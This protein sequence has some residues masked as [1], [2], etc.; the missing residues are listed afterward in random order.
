M[1]NGT[2][3]GH[4]ALERE[5]A[6]FYGCRSAIVFS[7]GYVANLGMLSALTGPGDVILI[8]SDCHASI[9]DG[10]RLSGA[11][12]IRFR[13]S[14]PSDLNKR[15]HRLGE[16]ATNALIVVEGIYS[17]LGDRAPLA[18]LAAVKDDYGAYLFVDEA[19]SL[20]VIGDH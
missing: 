6:D 4:V 5:L 10:C 19:H 13:H 1:A 17:M 15:L 2:F 8:D 16:R 20:G 9:Y 14:D 11:E 18:D 7:T 12:V 3:T